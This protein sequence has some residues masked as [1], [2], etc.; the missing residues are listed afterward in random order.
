MAT[1]TSPRGFESAEADEAIRASLRE[2]ARRFRASDLTSAFP[3]RDVPAGCGAGTT[4]S[5]AAGTC[6]AVGGA[7][8]DARAG[9][10]ALDV[11]LS[12]LFA[13]ALAL[14]LAG[15]LFLVI[16]W[17]VLAAARLAS[18]ELAAMAANASRRARG[19]ERGTPAAER[20]RLVS[21]FLAA[22]ARALAGFGE[23]RLGPEAKSKST[24]PPPSRRP[25]QSP[26][27]SPSRPRDRAAPV[28]ADEPEAEAED[29]TEPEDE[30]E[31]PSGV[32]LGSAM[33][34]ALARLSRAPTFGS[35]EASAAA[36]EMASALT[37]YLEAGEDAAE[38][39]R[40]AFVDAADRAFDAEAKTETKIDADADA[41]A[42]AEKTSRPAPASESKSNAPIRATNASSP[43]SSSTS[44]D[45]D[46]VLVDAAP[47]REGGAPGE[48]SSPSASATAS[49]WFSG[50]TNPFANPWTTTEEAKSPGRARG[51]S[52]GSPGRRRRR[53]DDDSDPF[54]VFAA[55]FAT[56][57]PAL[58]DVL[59]EEEEEEEDDDDDAKYGRSPRGSARRAGANTM[60]GIMAVA[61]AADDKQLKVLDLA[62]RMREVLSS[63]RANDIAEKNLDLSARALETQRLNLSVLSENNELHSRA[64]VIAAEQLEGIV[65]DRR[66][67]AEE[68]ALT[69]T[70][71]ALA[72]SFYAGLVVIFATTLAGGWRRAVAAL[73]SVVSVCPAP[74]ASTTWSGLAWSYVGGGVGPLD[75]AWCVAKSL[76][77]A[78]WGGALFAVVAWK[79]LQHNV[80]TRFQ[81]APATVMLVVLGAGCGYVGRNA[82]DSLGGDGELWLRLWRAYVASAAAAT[83]R[84]ANV[85][86]ALARVGPAGRAAFHVAL[87]GV[88]P[89]AVGALPFEDVFSALY[90]EAS[91]N[92]LVWGGAAWDRATEAAEIIGFGFVYR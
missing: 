51:A 50:F 85:R 43:S 8:S 47:T 39:F 73:T 80:V 10:G 2:E 70:R 29:E 22:A 56:P 55:S 24:A 82:V 1:P 54:A 64:N 40:A 57:P 84:A 31:E 52:G 88:F 49:D 66:A 23:T 42:D 76:V 38:E 86:R 9:A 75:Y 18:R 68:K 14:A 63:E 25:A 58:P 32:K 12:T 16:L 79:L 7:P 53:K 35:R 5:H 81:A 62:V 13:L 61:S 60:R 74:A 3:R 92:A 4:W 89:F 37:A 72:D 87:G 20:A 78:A 59:G 28:P 19:H 71:A 67:T 11:P 44:D 65:A 41:K 45:I 17:V 36:S 46:A 21:A 91:K 15:V 27:P 90:L 30:D 69:E 33:G 34:A 6:V 77:G 83:W 26:S 48:K